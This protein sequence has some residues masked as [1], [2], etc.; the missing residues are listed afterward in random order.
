M[1]CCQRYQTDTTALICM[2]FS[3]F[4]KKW[5]AK[6]KTDQWY[7]QF[8]FDFFLFYSKMIKIMFFQMYSN[9]IKN[10][11]KNFALIIWKIV[12]IHSNFEKAHDDK[13]DFSMDR[14]YLSKSTRS[15]VQFIRVARCDF[16]G[17]CQIVNRKIVKCFSSHSCSVRGITMLYNAFQSSRKCIRCIQ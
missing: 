11:N 10:K 14:I 13:L 1:S 12:A 6:N 9:R 2:F 8:S 7:E 15:I 16:S 17:A 4:C 3:R 5:L